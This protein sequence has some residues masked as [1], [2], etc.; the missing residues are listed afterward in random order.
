MGLGVIWDP[1]AFADSQPDSK[2]IAAMTDP[3]GAQ[4]KALADQQRAQQAV[5]AAASAAAQINAK[6]GIT[7]NQSQ[8]PPQIGGGGMGGMGGGPGGPPGNMNGSNGPPG[9]SNMVVT[10]NFGVPDRMVGLGKR[11]LISTVHRL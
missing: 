7:S 3:I 8:P 5:Q 2:K 1:V 9:M 6:L 11:F 10:E 4:L